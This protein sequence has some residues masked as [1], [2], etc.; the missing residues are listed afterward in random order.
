MRIYLLRHGESEANVAG[1]ISDDP[2]K[3]YHLTPMGIAQAEVAAEELLDV[4]FT[5]IYVS[6]H[7]R[8]RETAE[9]LVKIWTKAAEKKAAKAKKE[10]K[11]KP[12]EEDGN[13]GGQGAGA[14]QEGPAGE[15]F[16]ITPDP[17][18]NERHSAMDGRPVAEF[19]ALVKPDPV[20]IKPEGGES[21]L[22]EMDRL[23]AFL[24]AMA[25]RH[26]DGTILAVSHENPILAALAVAGRSQEEAAWGDVAN[27]AWEKI[28]W[29]PAEKAVKN[30]SKGAGTGSN[31]GVADVSN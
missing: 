29:P 17:R 10:Q 11:D 7:L 27:C 20:H 23:R 12:G 1:V 25:E 14:G 30:D 4:P 2:S 6:E 31:E 22:E 16:P 19:N 5:H 28:E 26:V 18:L 3:T 21:F 24:D 15:P 9:V 13:G 8:T